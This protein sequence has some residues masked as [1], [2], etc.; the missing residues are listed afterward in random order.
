MKVWLWPVWFRKWFEASPV[1]KVTKNKAANEEAHIESGLVHVHPPCIWTH[2]VKLRPEGKKIHVY[3]QQVSTVTFLIIYCNFGWNSFDSELWF[4][5]PPWQRTSCLHTDT[6]SRPYR[7][8]QSTVLEKEPSN[9]TWW[10]LYRK[11]TSTL[12]TKE[13][14]Y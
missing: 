5:S 13:V 1:S 12:Q 7:Q 3:I 14:S 11:L 10:L 9:Q 6:P 2:Q 4:F 8:K